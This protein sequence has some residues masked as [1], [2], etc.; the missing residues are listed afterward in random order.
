LVEVKLN[1]LGVDPQGGA[2]SK[3]GATDASAPKG[4]K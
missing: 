1:S 4:K 2:A 3:E